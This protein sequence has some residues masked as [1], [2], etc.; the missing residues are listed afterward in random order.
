LSDY[1]SRRLHRSWSANYLTNYWYRVWVAHESHKFGGY[2]A[3]SVIGFGKLNLPP[4]PIIVLAQH[5]RYCTRPQLPD[6]RKTGAR[7]RSN[8]YSFFCLDVWLNLDYT[9][10]L[11]ARGVWFVY[12][13]SR[14]WFV[15]A[16]FE[17]GC[18]LARKIQ[19]QVAIALA[20]FN[21]GPFDPL[22]EAGDDD[23]I[24][25]AGYGG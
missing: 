2:P 15:A 17:L 1:R 23:P 14:V 16:G 25:L 22:V 3:L 21:H 12:F 24:W 5:W 11:L 13:V 18:E 8:T 20:G 7:T 4:G 6:P 10:C 19:I 9:F